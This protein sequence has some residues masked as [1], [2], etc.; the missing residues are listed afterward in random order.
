MPDLPPLPADRRIDR[1]KIENY[2][3]HP[4]NSR[5]KAAF[6]Q[7]FGFSLASCEDLR[8]ALLAHA[9]SGQLTQAVRTGRLDQ[10]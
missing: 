10:V 9:A 3:L 2:L 4:I 6:F 1:S 7:A 5:G 8:D